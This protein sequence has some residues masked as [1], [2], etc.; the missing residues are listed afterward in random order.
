[1]EAIPP[2]PTTGGFGNFLAGL[3]GGGEP[4]L[5]TGASKLEVLADSLHS[6]TAMVKQ[7]PLDQQVHEA[8]AFD[9]TDADDEVERIE[10]LRARPASSKKLARL[11]VANEE[12]AHLRLAEAEAAMDLLRKLQNETRAAHP[13]TLPERSNKTTEETPQ[14]EMPKQKSDSGESGIPQL[15][16]GAESKG[17]NLFGFSDQA[18]AVEPVPGAVKKEDPPKQE[19]VDTVNTSPQV[20]EKVSRVAL[21]RAKSVLKEA[22]ARR[23]GTKPIKGSDILH[24]KN[25][26]PAAK[27]TPPHRAHHSFEPVAGPSSMRLNLTKG[28]DESE[29]RSASF[30]SHMSLLGDSRQKQTGVVVTSVESRPL[31]RPL[32]AWDI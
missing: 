16:K 22:S 17:W 27:P 6:P 15:G 20:L 21:E 3:V 1:M 32:N 2:P 9:R 24:H 7:T 23:N 11:L 30:S 25:T 14:V 13:L 29:G 31:H 8:V 10:R 5:E 28:F 19:K 18:K 12:E 26:K 4:K